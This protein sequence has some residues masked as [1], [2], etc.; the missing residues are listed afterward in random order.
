MSRKRSS[1]ALETKDMSAQAA[2]EA[3][4]DELCV[5]L[6]VCLPPDAKEALVAN[7]PGEV[8]AFTDAVIRA[9]GMDPVLIDS[10]LRR[11]IR[12]MVDVRIGVLLSPRKRS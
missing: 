8:E 7:P 5:R 12:E 1:R 11:S 2:V 6:G 9:E 4:L 10:G 3:L